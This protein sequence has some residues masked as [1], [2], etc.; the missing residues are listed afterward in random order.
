MR[1]SGSVTLCRVRPKDVTLMRRE[2][3]GHGAEAAVRGL[4]TDPVA[5]PG[6][7]EGLR[8]L[9]G[10]PCSAP[11]SVDTSQ[12]WEQDTSFVPRPGA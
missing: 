7:E 8:V 5:L 9:V 12:G 2:Q 4:G 10:V 1:N 3:P 6:L 11:P